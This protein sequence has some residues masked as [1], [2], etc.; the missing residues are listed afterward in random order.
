MGFINHATALLALNMNGLLTVLSCVNEPNRNATF[1]ENIVLNPNYRD[2]EADS[3]EWTFSSG[4]GS[5]RISSVIKKGMNS[6]TVFGA[7]KHRVN[8]ENN[9]F[10]LRLPSVGFN[11]TGKYIR[12]FTDLN[13]TETCVSIVVNV[14][15]ESKKEET[16][17]INQP[18]VEV[19][20]SRT[21]IYISVSIIGPIF[22]VI[23]LVLIIWIVRKLTGKATLSENRTSLSNQ[24]TSYPIYGNWKNPR[25]V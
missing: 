18:N 4:S 21:I 16:F 15:A 1:G 7:F 14:Y 9:G 23:I 5:R 2:C 22:G 10:Y 25:G 24:S 12:T 13:G 3:V 20:H 6:E 19:N 8:I 17:E 11:D